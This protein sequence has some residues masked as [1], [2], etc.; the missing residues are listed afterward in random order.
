MKLFSLGLAAVSALALAA[1]A[2]AATVLID[3]QFHDAG[4]SGPWKNYTNGNSF[5]GW[6]VTSGDVDL[7]G[8][9]WDG[10]GTSQSVDLDG[11]QPG[12][13]SQTLDLM[14]T[15]TYTLKFWLAGNP[16][17]GPTV[18][19]LDVSLGGVSLLSP[20]HLTFDTT[21]HSVKNMGWI[22]ETLTFTGSGKQD[23]TFASLDGESGTLFGP[24]VSDISISAVPESATWALMLV[25]FGSLGATLRMNR[26]KAAAAA[27]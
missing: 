5:G 6:T 19:T 2:Q 3:G 8:S 16:D 17:G 20:S 26:R 27:A 21:G 7:I 4:F 12:A 14:A 23:L 22:E 10:H 1:S 11:Y 13:I 24:A 18:K 25:G 15:K 9:S